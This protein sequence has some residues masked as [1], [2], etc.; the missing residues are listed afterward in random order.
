MREHHRDLIISHPQRQFP[1]LLSD[2]RYIFFRVFGGSAMRYNTTH[3]RR[4]REH[5][6]LREKVLFIFLYCQAWYCSCVVLA[7]RIPMRHVRTSYA[8]PV[9][10]YTECIQIPHYT[11][12]TLRILYRHKI[13]P[14]THTRRDFLEYRKMPKFRLLDYYRK[15]SGE[16]PNEP[17]FLRH[18]KVEGTI[19]RWGSSDGYIL[20][21]K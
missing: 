9:V 13:Q 19:P 6:H 20:E 18:R 11:N 5:T 2:L 17:V 1:S 16:I 14:T 21:K 7:A 4:I 12:N 8:V 10:L 15:L 3:T